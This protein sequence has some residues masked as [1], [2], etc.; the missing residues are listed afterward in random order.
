MKYN[1]SFG[2]SIEEEGWIPAPRYILRRKAFLDLIKNEKNGSLLE[3]GFGSGSI[4][5]ELNKMNFRCSGVDMSD[6]AH[7]LASVSLKNLDIDLAKELDNQKKNQ[8]DYFLAFEVLEHIEND[9]DELINWKEFLAPNGRIFI[10]VPAHK[11]LWGAT[12]IWAG[13]FRRY[14]KNE[15]LEVMEK[16]GFSDIKIYSYGWPLS[17]LVEPLRNRMHKNKL[18][19]EDSKKDDVELR[20]ERT[21][22]SGSDRMGIENILFKL[23]NNPAGYLVFNVFYLLQ[24]WTRNTNLGTGFI[25]TGIKK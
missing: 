24:Y 25:A 2:I 1:K 17:N 13:H 6:D 23:Y 22:K 8:F 19:K 15:L 12:D 3:V 20:A 18:G 9:L 7:R 16:A 11:K 14:E 21:A 4:L 5:Y 10:S